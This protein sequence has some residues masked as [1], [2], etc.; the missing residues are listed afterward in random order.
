MKRIAVIFC[1]IMIASMTHAATLRT[2]MNRASVSRDATNLYRLYSEDWNE[3]LAKVQSGTDFQNMSYLQIA[4]VTIVGTS[5]QILG[6][7]GGADADSHIEGDTDA[8]LFYCDAGNDRVGIGTATPGVKFEVNGAAKSLTMALG[9]PILTPGSD[10]GLTVNDAG[11]L[12]TQVYKVS[13]AKENFDTAAVNHDVTIGT[14]PAK[15][16]VLAVFGNVTEAF[17]CGSVCTTGTLS[18][19]VGISAGGVEF[20][21]SF[22]LDAATG[23]FGD[24]DAEVG[25]QLDI[26]ADRNGGY[27]STAGTAVVLRGVSGTGNW[28][29]GAATY[30]SAGAVTLYV[31][32]T[33]LP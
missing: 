30:L 27:I 3:L 21:E 31:L 10:T 18:A 25:S 8:N 29:D 13:L 7:E 15:T 19:T 2:L 14:L 6:N 17:V 28:G 32:Y 1:V 12:R 22:D 11:S 26:A 9:T 5:G 24:A 33:V 20:L 23:W 16:L 4:G